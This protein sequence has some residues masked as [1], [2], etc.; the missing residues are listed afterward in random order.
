MNAVTWFEIPAANFERACRFYETILAIQLKPESCGP[1]GRMAVWPHGM[2]EVGGCI[3]EN[4]QARPHQD[5]VRIYLDAG[6]DLNR[7]LMRVEA[8]G[9]QIIVPKTLIRPEIG[10]FAIL[11]DTEGNMV[12][13]HSPG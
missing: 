13:L 4:A 2:T 6:A 1:S 5:G 8:A 12:G 10:Y 7:V 9:G 3:F 11:A